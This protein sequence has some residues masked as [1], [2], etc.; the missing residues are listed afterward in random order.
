M[1]IEY[2]DDLTVID[3]TERRMLPYRNAKP[4]TAFRT[5]RVSLPGGGACRHGAQRFRW[6]TSGPKHLRPGWAAYPRRATPKVLSMLHSN[7]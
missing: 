6:Y 7:A 5:A 3:A 2:V 4:A 1:T